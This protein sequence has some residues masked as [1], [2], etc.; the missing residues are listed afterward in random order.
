LGGRFIALDNGFADTRP[1]PPGDG[2]VEASFTFELPF[3]EGVEIEQSLNVPVRAAVLVLP[4]GDYGLE[5]SGLSG[6]DALETE[7]GA[8]LSYIAGPLTAGERLAFMLVPRTSEVSQ[9]ANGRAGKG[10][11]AGIV[12]VVLA[13]ALIALMYLAPS[14]GPVPAEVRDQ[15]EA[16]AALDRDYKSGDVFE[17]AYQAKRRSLKNRLRKRLANRDR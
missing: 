9:E 2:S 16:I 10:L 13:G 8:A 11:T 6:E 7:M 3:Q 15:V 4:E 5:G 12:A 17:K 1:I 14:P